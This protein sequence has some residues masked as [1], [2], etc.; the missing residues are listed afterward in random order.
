MNEQTSTK[1]YSNRPLPPRA[2]AVRCRGAAA[3]RAHSDDRLA[4]V[5]RAVVTTRALSQAATPT[6]RI[7]R[8]CRLASGVSHRAKL[9]SGWPLQTAT[10]CAP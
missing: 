10:R 1:P 7:V 4:S 9:A 5:A 6:A 2:R 8:S 3:V